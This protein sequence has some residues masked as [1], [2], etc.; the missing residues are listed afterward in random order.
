VIIGK[1]IEIWLTRIDLQR[2]GLQKLFLS[3]V[4]T[5]VFEI[6]EGEKLRA[7]FKYSS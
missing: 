4:L 7:R 5:V 6:I 3:E 1:W 2:V